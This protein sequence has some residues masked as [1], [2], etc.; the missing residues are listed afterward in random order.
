MTNHYCMYIVYACISVVTVL[1]DIRWLGALERWCVCRG[2]QP[3]KINDMV[4][5]KT[6]TYEVPLDFKVGDIPPST[7]LQP[8]T[9]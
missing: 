8:P 3:I 9:A 7:M 6:N 4:K 2:D 5:V 1:T